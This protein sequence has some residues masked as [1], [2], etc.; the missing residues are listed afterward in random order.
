MVEQISEELTMDTLVV[1]YEQGY[2][3]WYVSEFYKH[4]HKTLC[5][6]YPNVKFKYTPLTKL[7]ERFSA[8]FDNGN[9]LFNWYNFVLYNEVADKFFVHS[10]YD[11]APEIVKYCISKQLNVV[12]FSCVSNLTQE[13]VEEHKHIIKIQPSVYCLENWT[14]FELIQQARG[15][16][17]K[18]N[19]CYYNGLSYGN[20][21]T[22]LDEL[23]KFSFFDIKDK[24]D[25]EDFRQKQDYFYDIS[26]YRF[27]LSLNGAAN[28]CYRDLELFGLGI[29]NLRQSKAFLTADPLIKDI[30]Y[31]D[32]VDEK[33][34]QALQHDT[35]KAHILI[36][37]KIEEVV[38]FSNNSLANSMIEESLLWFEKNCKPENQ[39]NILNSF[40]EE[41]TILT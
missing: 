5:E 40:L 39:V 19:R 37:Q 31:I 12:T 20:R 23:K 22:V 15:N 1:S 34:I 36:V 14:D 32:F 8:T 30:H 9:T 2:G 16:K 13:L 26:E 25:R 35:E 28:I 29:L 3:D 33:L 21:K 4:F 38:E 41:L 11:Y 18:Y 10:W 6:R 27:G 17:K 7:A 24:T